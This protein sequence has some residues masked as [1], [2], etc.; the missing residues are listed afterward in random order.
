MVVVHFEYEGVSGD[1]IELDPTSTNIDQAYAASTTSYFSRR[2]LFSKPKSLMLLIDNVAA[3]FIRQ[4][5]ASAGKL[6]LFQILVSMLYVAS[7]K[8]TRNAKCLVVN[9]NDTTTISLVINENFCIDS[10]LLIAPI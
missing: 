9:L 4:D 1:K 7:L 5:H 2:S 6:C 10:G 3:C 8:A